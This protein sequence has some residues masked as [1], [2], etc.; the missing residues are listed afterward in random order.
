MRRTRDQRGI[1]MVTVLFVAAVLTV[2]GSSATFITIHE[3]QSSSADRRSAEALGYAEAGVDRLM[4]ELRRGSITWGH[5]R[6]AGCARPPLA[7][8]TTSIGNGTYTAWLTV[9]DPNS[10]A[11][12]DVPPTPWTSANDSAAPCLGRSND[13]R[14]GLYFAIDV[15]GVHPTASRAVRQV[16]QIDTL[17][18]PIGLYAESVDANGNP[19]V[20]GMSVITPGDVYGREKLGFTGCDPYYKMNDFWPGLSSTQCVPAAVHALGAVYLKSNGGQREHPPFLNCT[21]NDG[22]GTR[23]QSQFDE[24]GGGAAITSGTCS[25]W[26]GTPSAP[27]PDSLFTQEDLARVVKRTGFSDQEYLTLKE[28]ARS[29]GIYCYFPTGG[30]SQ[31]TRNG[32]TVTG[33]GSVAGLPN[34]F[35]AYFDYQDASKAL[36]TNEVT[37][38]NSW[39]GCND[40]PDLN[41]SVVIIVRNGGM[42][43]A[44]NRMNNGAMFLPEGTFTDMGG[45][46]WNGT[47]IAKNYHS[48]GTATKTVDACWV[49][50]MPGTF[51]DVTPS[52]W[53]ELDRA[54]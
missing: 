45:H 11:G 14:A 34:N 17:D 8:P 4:Q 18:L 48:R 39:W 32:Q 40:N 16:V 24:S 47:I 44:A 2:V 23:G 38:N 35:V 42:R 53:S 5:V 50:N 28:A 19:D 26:A 10:G 15:K 52:T 25:N 37:W 1:A 21:A 33:Y 31:C 7:L 49:N 20:G 6:E 36:T 51:L 29:S 13:V 54:S 30:G 22:R 43:I 41:K 12:P 46:R 3:L 9:Y 27:P